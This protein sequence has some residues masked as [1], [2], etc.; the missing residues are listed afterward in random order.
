[1]YVNRFFGH[2][3]YKILFDEILLETPVFM[4]EV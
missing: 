1:M 2:L 4:M 3:F